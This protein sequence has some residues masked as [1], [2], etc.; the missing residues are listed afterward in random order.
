MYENEKS[1]L[2][3]KRINNACCFENEMRLDDEMKFELC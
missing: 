2:F 1:L 3:E